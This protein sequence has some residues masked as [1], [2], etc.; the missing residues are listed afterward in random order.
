[1]STEIITYQETQSIAETFAKSGYFAD[2][3]DMAQAV[4]K[5]MAGRELGLG[6]VAAMVGVYIVKGKPAMSANLLA[7]VLKKSGKYDYRVVKLTD[8]ECEIAFYQGKEEIGRSLFT[9]ADAKKAGTQNMEKFARNMLFARAFT[10]GCRWYCPDVFAGGL[11]TP[12]ELGETV[13]GESGEINARPVAPIAEIV[14]KH[15]PVA[16]VAPMPDFDAPPPAV[17]AP[18]APV[19]SP[20]VAPSAKLWQR[21]YQ[22]E[23]DARQLGL[24]PMTVSNDISAE[25]LTKLGKELKAKIAQA[26]A[27]NVAKQGGAE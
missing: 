10:N 1:M 16:P 24:E 4:V 14:S 2:A 27:E 9:L 21:Y 20:A 5:I 13:D 17:V 19:T 23:N 22:L 25:E 6:P 11:Y 26:S 3:R 7:G 18:A 8:A 12:E 15:T